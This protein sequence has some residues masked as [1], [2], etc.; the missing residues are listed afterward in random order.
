[1]I[2]IRIRGKYAY[3]KV[4]EKKNF[5][6]IVIS[7]KNEIIQEIE[8]TKAHCAKELF[9]IKKKKD[10]QAKKA[11]NGQKATKAEN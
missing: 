8:G 11:E 7:P 9:N 4:P 3:I 1:M 5:K 2:K 6:V 10:E